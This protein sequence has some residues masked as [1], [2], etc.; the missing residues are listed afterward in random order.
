M[1]KAIPLRVAVSAQNYSHLNSPEMV[2]LACSEHTIYSPSD[3]APGTGLYVL[4]IE[5]VRYD[6]GEMTH[7]PRIENKNPNKVKQYKNSAIN[8]VEVNGKLVFGIREPGTVY[9]SQTRKYKFEGILAHC[10][11][12]PH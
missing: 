10:M 9:S 4:P 1:S 7:Q 5:S 6:F 3:F 12:R 11:G 8:G 2:N